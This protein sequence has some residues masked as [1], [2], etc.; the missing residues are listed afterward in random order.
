MLRTRAGVVLAAMALAGG[1]A[2]GVGAPTASAAC[3]TSTTTP[4]QSSCPGWH[5]VKWGPKAHWW[6]SRPCLQYR[7]Y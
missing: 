2:V 4:G 5:C 3:T 1:L 6:S 7:W